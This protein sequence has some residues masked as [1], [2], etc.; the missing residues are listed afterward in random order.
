MH[1][2]K[3]KKY[4]C[5]PCIGDTWMLLQPRWID[6]SYEEF[7]KVGKEDGKSVYEEFYIGIRAI[8]PEGEKRKSAGLIVDV[9]HSREEH[10]LIYIV[11]TLA[12]A[13]EI[14]AEIKENILVYIDASP[15]ANVNPKKT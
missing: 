8:M 15:K 6:I 1:I 4:G 14:A 13:N 3:S 10:T 12:E 9:Y 7:E 5:V 2:L 11:Q